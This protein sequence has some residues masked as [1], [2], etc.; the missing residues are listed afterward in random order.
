MRTA[1]ARISFAMGGLPGPRMAL[2]S[3]FLA[4]SSRCQR[5]I[6]SGVTIGSVLFVHPARE[7]HHKHL[8]RRVQYPSTRQVQNGPCRPRLTWREQLNPCKLADLLKVGFWN[9]TRPGSR[10]RENLGLQWTG[11]VVER[12]SQP[13]EPGC[14]DQHAAPDGTREPSST[15]QETCVYFVNRRV[16][17]RTH[18]GVGGR[19]P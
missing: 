1:S 18:G 2:P 11:T 3:Y 4:T 17:N 9:R 14:T 5:R 8:P 6:V 16:R 19:R 12:G 10:P 13:H 15:T 7:H